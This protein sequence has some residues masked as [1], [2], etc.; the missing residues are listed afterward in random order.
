MDQRFSTLLGLTGREGKNLVPVDWLSAAIAHLFTHPEHHGRVYHLTHPHPT[1]VGMIQRVIQEAIRSYSKRPTAKQVNAEELATYERLFYSQMTVYR[2]H[3]R[4]DPVFDRTNA[5]AALA[6]FPCPEMDHAM[7]MRLARYPIETNFG[8]RR[9]EAVVRDS[10]SPAAAGPA[11]CGGRWPAGRPRRRLGQHARQRPRRR[12]VAPAAARRDA[13]RGRGGADRPRRRRLS[14]QCQGTFASVARGRSTVGESIG[15][16][17]IV[18][19][20][21]PASRQ[22]IIRA[23]EQVTAPAPQDA[24]RA[25]GAS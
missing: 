14:S 21:P 5:D 12:A 7:L 6:G 18:I 19:E 22:Q 8:Q 20:G 16:G 10:T 4:D 17:Q 11:G 23:L 15:R 1:A 24:C 2:S 25:N 9:Y 13:D 3:W